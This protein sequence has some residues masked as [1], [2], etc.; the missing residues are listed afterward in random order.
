MK[1]QETAQIAMLLES[2]YSQFK[3]DVNTKKPKGGTAFITDF[4]HRKELL[5]LTQ[6][7]ANPEAAANAPKPTAALAMGPPPPRKM[8]EEH[9]DMPKFED[10]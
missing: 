9:N 3:E 5:A 10:D 1:K 7:R 4:D 8:E 2:Q 6:G